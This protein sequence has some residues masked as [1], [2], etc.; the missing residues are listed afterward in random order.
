ME[1][2]GFS[3]EL[4]AVTMAKP[5]ALFAQLKVVGILG[6]RSENEICKQCVCL[7]ARQDQ[8]GCGV[9]RSEIREKQPVRQHLKSAIMSR[10]FGQAAGAKGRAIKK[11]FR[12][13][14]Q[15]TPC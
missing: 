3:A 10:N 14:S 8:K 9:R 4:S 12:S 1:S 2:S 7:N 5:L 13:E 6:V 11:G 15:D